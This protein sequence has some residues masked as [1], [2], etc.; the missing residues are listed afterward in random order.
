MAL[1]PTLF[2]ALLRT[3]RPYDADPTLR[4]LL[5]APRDRLFDMLSGTWYL[6]DPA[7]ITVAA[8]VAASVSTKAV[9]SLFR[10]ARLYDPRATGEPGEPPHQ[11]RRCL[12]LEMRRALDEH[13]EDEAMLTDAAFALL[14]RLSA[15]QALGERLIG[16]P[17]PPRST[18]KPPL[19]SVPSPGDVLA[20]HPLLRRDTVLLL[21][22]DGL[23]G[24]AMGLVTNAPTPAKL[25][26]S[27]FSRPFRPRERGERNNHTTG[28]R[29]LDD[30]L[31]AERKVRDDDVTPFE[32]HVIFDGGPD[33]SANLTMLHPYAC[34]RGSVAVR[35]GLYYGGDLAHAAQLVRQGECDARHFVFYKGRV[36]WR[37]GELHGELV[38]GEWAL[39]APTT[40]WPPAGLMPNMARHAASTH[41]PPA[42]VTAEVGSSIA[43]GMADKAQLA[44]IRNRIEHYR[45]AAW[46]V[47]VEKL[48]SGLSDWL[49]VR[50]FGSA[51]AAELAE[52]AAE[53][54]GAATP[55]W[56]MVGGE[57]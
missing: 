27:S 42:L 54:A 6:P 19:R 2:R 13:G 45:M 18:P 37:P 23:D 34:V 53:S 12:A 46:S 48:Y 32:D 10:G 38:M 15:G 22:A 41:E 26:G 17:P 35:E 16:P 5:H 29:V 31:A 1:R 30:A 39:G 3:T 50:S 24:Y 49:R 25:G 20:S 55:V 8:D 36:D 9:I 40:A 51:E 14:R 11:F 33:G 57:S 28:G 43:A 7:P 44:R 21:T 56:R 52:L 4:L 47:V